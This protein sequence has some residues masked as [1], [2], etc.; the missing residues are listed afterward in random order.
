MLSNLIQKSAQGI[1]KVW[2]HLENLSGRMHK[3]RSG[4]AS[5]R[6]STLLQDLYFFVSIYHPQRNTTVNLDLQLH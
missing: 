3:W 1:F 5:K 2:T 4:W 6:H